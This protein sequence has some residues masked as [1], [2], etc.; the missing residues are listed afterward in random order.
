MK[1]YEQ[2]RIYTSDEDQMKM[3]MNMKT[4]RALFV[5]LALCINISSMWGQEVIKSVVVDEN[6]LPLEF[7][8]V[9]AYSKDSTLLKGG[10]TDSIGFFSIEKSEQMSYLCFT[11]IGYESQKIDINELPVEVEMHPTSYTLG[12]VIIKGNTR[13][14]KLSNHQ[15][16]V[17][18]E[19]TPLAQ[20]SSIDR[21]LAQLPGVAVDGNGGATLLGGGDILILLDNKEVLSQDELKSIDPKVITTITFDRNPGPRYRGSVNA[22]LHIKTKRQK[23]NFTGQ[24]KSKLQLNHAVSYLGDLLLGYVNDKCNISLQ[25]NQGDNRM[26]KT[27]RIDAQ[28]IP[29]LYLQTQ[30]VDTISDLTRNILLKA[31]FTPH[32][33][34]TWGLGY[35]LSSS[36]INSHS[37]DNTRYNTN[38]QGWQNLMSNTYLDNQTTSHHFS[39]Y[40]EWNVTNRFKLEINADAF[41]KSLNRQQATRENDMTKIRNHE[42]STNAHY[43]LFQLSPYLSYSFID[44][45]TL[46]GG[47]DLYQINGTRKQTTDVRDQNM[48][49]NH[50]RVYAGYLNYSFPLRMWSASLGVRFEHANS[51]LLDPNAPQNNIDRSYN[52]IFFVGKIAGKIGMSMHNFSI[53]SGTRRPSLEDLSNNS[54]YSNQ[55]VS[56]NSN[57]NLLPEKNYRIGYEFIYKILYL[58]VNY[59][60]SRDHI[61]NY[62]QKKD[63]L[64]SGYIISKA[65]FDHHHR[66]Q[67]MGNI[68]KG[69]GWYSINL[70]GMVQLEQLDGRKYNL[71]I[72]QKPLFYTR[73]T[74]TF[75]VPRW[76]DI[77][78]NYS[79][80]SPL[81]SGIFEAGQ[82]HQ[83]DL[84][85]RKQFLGGKMDIS[86]LGTD[87]LKTAWDIGSTQIEGIRLYD[88][89][90][91]DTRSVSIQLRYRF[92]QKSIRQRKST[93][94]ES[95]S[96]LNM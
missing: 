11:C 1:R 59:Q 30:L 64:T 90:Y 85:L 6:K 12:E 74:Q 69:W 62:I 75:A 86:I 23:D 58:G 48:G 16:Q 54:Y 2:N 61:D 96:R 37:G 38:K 17:N 36:K 65:N 13:R 46:E 39:A 5:L 84:E 35:N 21:L 43:A 89:T 29:Q 63:D 33:T 91:R 44:S 3:T 49:T 81:T 41:I 70:L 40:T 18:V 27:E 4:Y 83:L 88:K 31:N 25:L 9:V 80:Q 51:L 19:G 50:E 24:A 93:A 47:V 42:I 45:R 87:L 56:S 71:N 73:L 77:E 82:K 53:T 34:L 78:L 67:L 57:P 68:S 32:K 55:F 66:V 26:N 95:I 15:L 76:F 10:V 28:V 8:N 52:D 92:N 60:Y 79:Y 7:C 72:K 22:V 20:Q 94:T 14:L